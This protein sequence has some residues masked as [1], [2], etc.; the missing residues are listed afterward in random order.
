MDKTLHDR[1]PGRDA[2]P[3]DAADRTGIAPGSAEA[4]SDFVTVCA[5]CPGIHVLKI[6]RRDTDVII[7]F[8][9]GKRLMI[10]R[11]GSPMQISDGICDPCRKEH[12]GFP[13]KVKGEQS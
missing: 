10:S 11:N 3:A 13:P 8:Q 6:Q 12:F 5:W 2:S 7:A 4:G 1:A 9:Q